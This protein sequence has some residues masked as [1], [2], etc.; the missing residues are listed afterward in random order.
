MKNEHDMHDQFFIEDEYW[1]SLKPL[2]DDKS[3]YDDLG[4]DYQCRKCEFTVKH[5]RIMGKKPDKQKVRNLLTHL[6]Y[7][8]DLE[9]SGKS[10][11]SY[12]GKTLF[13][14]PYCELPAPYDSLSAIARDF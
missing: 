6:K 3:T 7:H 12:H 11:G 5:S 1:K 2:M 4:L 9:A 10:F 14:C 8:Q 13:P